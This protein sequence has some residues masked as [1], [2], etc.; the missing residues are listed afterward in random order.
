[1][2]YADMV[3]L[4]AKPGQDILDTLTPGKVNLWHMGT[5]ICGEAGEL[6]DAIKKVVAYNKVVDIENVVEELGDLEFYMEGVR[7]QMGIT[8]EQTL[9]YNQEKLMRKRYPNGYSDQ[10]AQARADKQEP[11]VRVHNGYVC[12]VC[13]EPQF[14]TDSGVTCKNGHGGEI[15]I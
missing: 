11:E 12:P 7:Q 13:H 14:N 9:A 3:T 4:L 5:G 1:M 6:L 10:A 2:K 15:G 8:R